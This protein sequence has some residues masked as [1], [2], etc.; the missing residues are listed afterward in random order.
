M[1][2]RNQ[3]PESTN[4]YFMKP[5]TRAPQ[6]NLDKTINWIQPKPLIGKGFTLKNFLTKPVPSKILPVH[7]SGSYTQTDY[8]ARSYIKDREK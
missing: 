8:D 6:S 5:K 2:D 4:N 3:I 7:W 1:E